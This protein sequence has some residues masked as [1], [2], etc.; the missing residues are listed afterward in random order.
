MDTQSRR[1]ARQLQK[2]EGSGLTFGV[3]GKPC[4]GQSYEALG[5]QLED[6]LQPHQPARPQ[7]LQLFR[8]GFRLAAR[9]Q[10]SIQGPADGHRT[11]HVKLQAR[12]R[13]PCTDLG[14]ETL[15]EQG[16]ATHTPPG[17]TVALRASSD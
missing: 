3:G 17:S 4:V 9:S 12:Q 2:Q 15:R 7:I 6:L 14:C 5:G 1:D 11:A 10:L 16:Q 13:E 8:L